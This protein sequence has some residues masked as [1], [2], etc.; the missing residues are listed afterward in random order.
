[1]P[2]F[3]KRSKDRLNTCDPRLVEVF[4]EV[5]K[6]YDCSVLEGVR[7][8]EDQDEYHRT[9]KSKLKWPKSKHNVLNP[10]DKSKAADVVPYPIDWNNRERFI[11]F[12]GFVL[13][14]AAAKGY[15]MRSGCDWDMDLDVREHSFFDGPH[16]EILD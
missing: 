10:T 14:V 12:A 15:R 7:S 13:G 2:S 9:G 5:V 6:H 4:E 11:I 16:F 1:M 3:S 8:K